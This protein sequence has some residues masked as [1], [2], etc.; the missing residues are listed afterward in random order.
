MKRGLVI[1]M[2]CL[3]IGCGGKASAEID[4]LGH[5]A[6]LQH[7]TSIDESMT[8]CTG[9]IDMQEGNA[10]HLWNACKTDM[11]S[12][13]LIEE[14][15]GTWE[16]IGEGVARA[17]YGAYFFDIIYSDDIAIFSLMS[18]SDIYDRGNMEF[19]VMVKNVN[20]ERLKDYYRAR[21]CPIRRVE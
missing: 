11:N 1:A 4:S 2:L 5:W 13:Y 7:T 3:M 12:C 16:L 9:D 8:L 20:I 15:D 6:W 10:F 14:A 18:V 21:Q 17:W 19:G